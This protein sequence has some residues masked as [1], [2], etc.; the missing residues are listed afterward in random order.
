MAQ[1]QAILEGNDKEGYGVRFP[2]FPGCVTVGDTLQEVLFM[3]QEALSLHLEG[4]L[5]DGE[6]I[7]SP[8]YHE[9]LGVRPGEI[10]ALVDVDVKP[11]KSRFNVTLD[12]SL[13][14][15]ID[16][17]VQSGRYESRSAF[18]AEAARRELSGLH[19]QS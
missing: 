12:G 2:Q 6:D 11:R 18:L 3:A 17:L 5:E 19:R 9:D 16:G 4:M 8:A 1:Y 15:Y 10:I 7:E 14:K 13:V